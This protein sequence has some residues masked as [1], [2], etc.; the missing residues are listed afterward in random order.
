MGLVHE[1]NGN[2]GQTVDLLPPTRWNSS[3]EKRS[4]TFKMKDPKG[5]CLLTT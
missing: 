3:V 4:S 2:A 1:A 5:S